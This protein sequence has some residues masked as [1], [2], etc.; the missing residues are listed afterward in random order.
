MLLDSFR[1]RIFRYRYPPV[2]Q[3]FFRFFQLTTTNS[4]QATSTST[5]LLCGFPC[6]NS[7]RYSFS[8]LLFFTRWYFL[9]DFETS[10]Y[11]A[12]YHLCCMDMNQKVVL[13]CQSN[14][15]DHMRKWVL[16]FVWIRI[17]MSDVYH[18]INFT[19]T[20]RGYLSI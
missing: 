4:N 20:C 1:K 2:V 3:F 19:N 13:I 18:Y 15:Y 14:W 17:Y 9:F 12:L 6:L 7:K 11:V 10:L 5:N 8:L 16:N